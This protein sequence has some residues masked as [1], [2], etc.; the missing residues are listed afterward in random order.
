[1]NKTFVV[2]KW[3]Y[4]EKVRSKAFIIGLFLMPMIIAVTSI[5]PGLLAGKEDESTKIVGV[6]DAT[7]QRLDSLLSLRMQRYKLS[8]G[9]PNYLVQSIASGRNIDLVGA[10]EEADKKVLNEDIEG[11]LVL[12]AGIFQDSVLEYRSRD[13]G[14]IRLAS[15]LQANM[16]AI[17]LDKKLAEQGLDPALAKIL[18]SGMDVRTVKISK[19]GAKEETDFMQTFFYAFIPL[20][21]L[22]NLFITSGQL[23]VRSMLDE[24]SNRIVE[25]LVSSCKPVELMT[26][27]LLG[28]CA[29]GLT[30][31]GFWSIIGA[32]AFLNFGTISFP[33]AQ[34]L[35]LVGVYSILGY[36]FYSAIFI[37][38]GSPVTTE[39][40]AQ[41][42]KSYLIL[43]LVLPIALV[44][45]IILQPSAL[46]VKILSY[47][48]IFTP[49]FMVL[50]L[51]IKMPS[52]LE[53][54]A[55]ILLLLLATYFMMVAAGRIFRI[56]I[57]ATGKRPGVREMMR[58][59]R[60]G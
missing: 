9:N 37:A 2:A 55:T 22:F 57:L 7:D 53:I 24:K 49:T 51:L 46:W 45:P 41:Q 47:I 60:E 18:R 27:K 56:A 38:L 21:M 44:M 35:L 20:M 34:Q 40:E 52:T 30:Q 6:I 33:P 13:A 14:D 29:L 26:G 12:T 16:K 39:Q 4:L 10:T 28:L 25:V 42:I 8:N 58:W 32:A 43:F 31:I 50:R 17:L 23:L 5:L 54:I 1:M 19:S 36:L 11:Y 48:P 3:E 59:V 15:R